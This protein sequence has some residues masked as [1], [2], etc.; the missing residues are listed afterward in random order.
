MPRPTFPPLEDDFTRALLR[1]AEGDEPSNAAYAKAATA[2]GVGAGL[3]VGASLAAPSLLAASAAGVARWSGL[4][5]M[6]LWA[7]GVSGVVLVGGGA[8]LLV[9]RAPSQAT[10]ANNNPTGAALR[11]PR[12]AAPALKQSVTSPLTVP[13]V[14]RALVAPAPDTAPLAPDTAL[15]PTTSAPSSVEFAA[16]ASTTASGSPTS[17]ATEA[18][19]AARG[20]E[21]SPRGAS[22]AV[23]R[24]VRAASASAPL[25]S[26][27]GSPASSLAEQVR[28]L[29]RA[30]VALGFG[31]AGTA[32]DEIAHYRKAWP[33]GVFLTEASVLEIEALAARGQR[34]LAAARAA[35]FV[36]AHPDSPQAERL[37]RLIPVAQP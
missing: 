3:G 8:L 11:A 5:A 24:A 6:R 18:E 23:R 25:A 16:P 21:A 9:A 22:S 15:A 32:L 1:S 28:S 26:A 2:L 4:S 14:A 31:D 35:S 17:R 13:P 30:R 36:A 34:A 29:D 27:D 33:Q 37:R 19:L 7:L 12:A 20:A 10:E